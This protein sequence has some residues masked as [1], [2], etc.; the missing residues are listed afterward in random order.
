MRVQEA[1]TPKD[2]RRQAECRIRHKC[3]QKRQTGFWHVLLVRTPSMSE[4]R[5]PDLGAML[6]AR[7]RSKRLTLRD[8]AHEIDV[9]VN[10]LSRV[11]RGH[12]P[13]LKNFQRIVDWLEVPAENFLEAPDD[14]ASTPEVIARHLRSDQRLTPEAAVKIA[15]LVEDM[16]HDFAREHRPVAVQ[17]RSAKAFT[18][19]ASV[20]LADILSEMQWALLSSPDG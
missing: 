1:P 11:E 6:K 20:L 4:E 13:D 17:L 2:R 7:R 16:Y 14:V 5:A 10:T 15:S 12:L 3:R 19:A 18:P 8:L 9:S